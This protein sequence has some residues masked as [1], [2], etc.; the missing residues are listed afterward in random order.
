VRAD[1]ER[2]LALAPG[3]EPSPRVVPELAGLRS[4]GARTEQL[5]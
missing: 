4:S 3:I 2:A 1:L 5:A